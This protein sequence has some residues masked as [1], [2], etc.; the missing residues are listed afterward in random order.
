[1]AT[2]WQTSSPKKEPSSRFQNS[3]PQYRIARGAPEAFSPYLFRHGGKP[4]TG[5]ATETSVSK[6]NSRNYQNSTCKED[7]WGISWLH[8]P[9][10]ET[11]R[12]ITNDSTTRKPSFTAP[13]GRRKSPTHLFYCRKIPRSLRPR[14]AP[15]PEAAIRKYLS[16]SFQTFVKLADFYYQK[17]NKRN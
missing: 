5:P 11:S 7:S 10:T 8:E 4:S 15:E 13:C 9:T 17:V 6:L 14:L 1:M 16:R 12:T 2:S 3:C